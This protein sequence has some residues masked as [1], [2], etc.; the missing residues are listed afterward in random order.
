MNPTLRSRRLCGACGVEGRP[1]CI[2][3][4]H[5]EA[6]RSG[7]VSVSRETSGRRDQALLRCHSGSGEQAREGRQSQ[8][9]C[10]RPVGG[11]R[12]P[13][14]CG[15]SRVVQ[16]CAGLRASGVGAASRSGEVVGR[17]GL[18]FS[19][20]ASDHHCGCVGTGRRPL[21]QRTVVDQ[22][23]EATAARHARRWPP[24][25]SPGEPQRFGSRLSRR[26][27][28]EHEGAEPGIHGWGFRVRWLELLTE[29]RGPG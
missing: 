2:T 16:G 27:V 17:P 5:V 3:G 14:E 15:S 23:A 19:V 18:Q 13:D 4:R 12:R 6:W 8:H 21:S 20:D 28:V 11:V 26:G 10:A 29:V 1:A 24:E 25:S 9:G 22:P 7:R